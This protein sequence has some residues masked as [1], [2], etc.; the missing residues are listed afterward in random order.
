MNPGAQ[1]SGL[2]NPPRSTRNKNLLFAKTPLEIATT[3]NTITGPTIRAKVVCKTNHPTD[4]TW[5]ESSR[6]SVER[7]LKMLTNDKRLEF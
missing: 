4:S 1:K 2:R 7:G 3:K 5:S 6:L